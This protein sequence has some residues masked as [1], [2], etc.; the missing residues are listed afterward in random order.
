MNKNIIS[1]FTAGILALTAVPLITSAEDTHTVVVIGFDGSVL[2]TLTVPDGSVL[3]LSVIDTDSLN[4]HPDIYT[5]IAF[6]SWG[7][8]P[9]NNIVTEDTA[10]Y[11]LFRKMVI[12][13]NEFPEKSEY[14]SNTGSIDLDGLDITITDYVQ[15]PERDSNGAFIVKEEV[16][17]IE[18]K[19]STVPENLDKAFSDGK[20]SAEVYVYPINSDIPIISYDITY[21]E[22]LGDVNGNSMVESTDASAILL[23]YA[24]ISIGDDTVFNDRQKLRADVN[25]DNVIDSVDASLV[26]SYYTE[27]ST[28]SEPVAWDEFLKR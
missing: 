17:N 11:A 13:C 27:L 4:Q 6:S 10:V 28:S 2:D 5:Q 9:E 14:F 8:L 20:T 15:L 16:T 12:S 22:G 26:I 1:C 23:Y 19:C 21:F 18:S 25:R 3:D 7:N 24:S